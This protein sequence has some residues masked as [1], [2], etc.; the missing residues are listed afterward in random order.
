[1]NRLAEPRHRA[2]VVSSFFVAAYLGLGAPAVLTGL[3]SLAVGPVGASA[4]VAALAAA[5]VVAAFA[6]V[7]RSFGTAPAPAPPGAPCDSWC[8][9]Q[10]Q[11]MARAAHA[12]TPG[13]GRR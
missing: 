5:I 8:R 12:P 9:P 3:I 10:Q 1:V 13:P 7:R 6:V 11:A 4:Y 2:A